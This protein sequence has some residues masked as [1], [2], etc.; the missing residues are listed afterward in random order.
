M[1]HDIVPIVMFLSIAAMVIGVTRIVSD[2]KTRRLI[3]QSGVS[4]ELA[5]AIA[6]GAQRDPGLFGALRWGLLVGAVGVALIIIQFIPFR[7]ED[8]ISVGIVLVGAAAGLLAYYA[9]AQR[10]A[11]QTVQHRYG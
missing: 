4:P 1:F 3:V 7:P 9:A 8:P 5:A 2:G 11:R 10:V 6:A